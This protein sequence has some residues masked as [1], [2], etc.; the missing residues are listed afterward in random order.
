MTKKVRDRIIKKYS[1]WFEFWEH[2]G[3]YFDEFGSKQRA[4]TLKEA[5]EKSIAKWDLC[6]KGFYTYEEKSTCGLC[7]LFNKKNC[8]KCPIAIET[9]GANCDNNKHFLSYQME[10]PGEENKYA[11]LEKTFLIR[12]KKRYCK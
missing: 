4:K 10:C 7:D 9:E 3:E 11:K 5:F 6:S 12:L 2:D 8:S 1:K